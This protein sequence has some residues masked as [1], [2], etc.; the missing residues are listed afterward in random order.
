MKYALT[1]TAAALV[2]AAPI[3]ATEGNLTPASAAPVASISAAA[4][5]VSTPSFKSDIEK[6]S[7]AVGMT[8]ADSFKTRPEFDGIA[9][10]SGFR[11]AIAGASRITDQEKHR[12][13]HG[14]EWKEIRGKRDEEI[15][16]CDDHVA[17]LRCDF[18]LFNSSSKRPRPKRVCQF[19][20]KNV[21]PHWLR[22]E[23]E[24]DDPTSHPCD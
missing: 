18:K 6:R 2:A 19:M 9:I 1:F 8:I 11:D 10:A 22:Q 23:Q 13:T 14:I 15:G 17:T 21:N 24:H 4:P 12:N 5:K 20:T 3:F 16:F 7:Y